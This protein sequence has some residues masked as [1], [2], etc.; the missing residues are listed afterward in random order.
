MQ[1]II[2]CGCAKPMPIMGSIRDVMWNDNW[3]VVRANGGLS[4]QFE[5]SFLITESGV[6]ILVV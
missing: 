4:P 3:T 5:H 2:Y 6:E 1:L